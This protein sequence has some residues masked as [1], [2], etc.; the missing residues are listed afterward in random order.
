[1]S[2]PQTSKPRGI[3]IHYNTDRGCRAGDSCKFLHGPDEQLTPYDKSKTCRFYIAGYCKRGDKC[4]FRHAIPDP[5]SSPNGL[6]CPPPLLLPDDN[7]CGICL[8]EPVTF[9]LLSGCSHVFCI[10]CIR[11]WRDPKGKTEDVLC[12]RVNKKCPY[13][14]TS[15]SL[16]LPSSL[17]YPEGHPGK[18]LVFDRYKSS[19][20]KVPCK[21][22][23]NSPPKDRYCPFGCDCL[24]QHRNSDNTPYVFTK[25]VGHYMPV[26]SFCVMTPASPHAICS[27]CNNVLAEVEEPTIPTHTSASA[28]CAMSAPLS[29]TFSGICPQ[30]KPMR[31]KSLLQVNSTYVASFFLSFYFFCKH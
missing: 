26:S 8:E 10:E 30:V 29:S 9:G 25:G 2:R 1:M 27:K 13:C 21:Y 19:L 24:Y 5:D 31:K 17:F 14:R 18:S 11:S 4:W 7:V 15:S 16:I 12:S 6:Q 3:C 23:Q 20:S 22:F 28:K